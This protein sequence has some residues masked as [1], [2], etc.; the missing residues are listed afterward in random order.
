M[1]Q[2][3]M[4]IYLISLNINKYI[5]LLDKNKQGSQNY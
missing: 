3:I 5:C 1:K 4:A 2:K